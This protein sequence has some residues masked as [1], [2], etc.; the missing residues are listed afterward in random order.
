MV[1]VWLRLIFYCEKWGGVKEGLEWLGVIV[2]LLLGL[3]VDDEQCGEVIV[4]LDD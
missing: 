2:V 3:V 1:W 4:V